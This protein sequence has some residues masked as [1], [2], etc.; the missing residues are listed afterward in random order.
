MLISFFESMKYMGHL[1]PIALFRLYVGYIY[2]S[3]A[4]AKIQQG[5]LEQPV[6]IEVFKVDGN[7]M[8]GQ[9]S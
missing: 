8:N 4:L 7:M 5:F 9:W 1:W 6:L 3:T 2:V